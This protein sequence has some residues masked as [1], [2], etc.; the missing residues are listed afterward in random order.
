MDTR[1]FLRQLRKSIGKEAYSKLESYA[2]KGLLQWGNNAF[3]P[4]PEKG[5]GA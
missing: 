5:T 3:E 4:G 2:R 1:D